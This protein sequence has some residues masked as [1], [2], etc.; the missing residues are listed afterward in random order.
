MTGSV[1]SVICI[2]N[3]RCRVVLWQKGGWRRSKMTGRSG[4][5]LICISD[6][7]IWSAPGSNEN[8]ALERKILP[9]R[10]IWACL[11]EGVARVCSI[12]LIWHWKYIEEGCTSWIRSTQNSDHNYLGQ[13][14][15]EL[16]GS[17]SGFLLGG[18]GA[19]LGLHATYSRSHDRS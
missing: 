19:T 11:S 6:G 3:P 13:A 5:Y 18:C 2:I 12:V 17:F 4:E 10:L 7:G 14:R 1:S 16:L 8:G 15:V 9:C